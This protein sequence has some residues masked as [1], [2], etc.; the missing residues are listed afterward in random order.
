MKRQQSFSSGSR[1]EFLKMTLAGGAGLAATRFAV[2]PTAAAGASDILVVG[3]N[4]DIPP[5]DPHRTLGW[6]TMLVTLTMGEQLIGQDLTTT[7][8]GTP[9]ILPILAERYEL[10]DD[11]L[12]YTY[13]LR[14]NVKFHDG[15]PFNADAV[16]FNIRRQWDKSFKFFYQDAANISFW[17]YQ[18]LADIQKADDLTVK[19]V[20]SQPWGDFLR[21]NMQSFGQQFMLSPTYVRK[22]GNAAAGDAPVLT[23]PFKFVERIPGERIV[24][25]RNP[26][27]WGA[28]PKLAKIIFRVMPDDAARKAALLAGEIDIAQYPIAWDSNAELQAKDMAV[29]T[30]NGPFLTYLAFNMKDPILGQS[31][32]VRQAINMAIDRKGMVKGLFGD[33]A[34]PANSMLPA[35]SPSYDPDLKG[36]TYDPDGARALLKQ[37]GH[38]SGFSTQ[39]LIPEVSDSVAQWIQRNLKD[40]GI[41]LIINKLD[42]NTYSGKWSAGLV[43]DGMT[44]TEWGMTSDYWIDL[45]T[46]STRQPPKGA[47]VGWY[48]NTK[49]DDLLIQAQ[50]ENDFDTR[51][52]K[53]RQVGAILHDDAGHAPLYNFRQPVAVAPYV[54]GFVR[55][56]E[57]WFQFWTVYLQK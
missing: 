46:R 3:L 7:A 44:T 50:S 12:T 11:G 22:V 36:Y 20:L 52:A 33:W 37:A 47:N 29:T 56:D 25:E 21:M 39:I 34:T 5:L 17:P 26:D 19:L 8:K 24:V 4:S 51:R 32:E 1:R 10:A 38:D 53:Y 55:P 23:G 27:Y 54:K 43:E 9:P 30:C 18:F 35:S 42:Y 48:T 57:D 31:K 28:A 40:V 2:S 6:T 15:T 16:D 49:V 45:V 14:P 41:D 13:H